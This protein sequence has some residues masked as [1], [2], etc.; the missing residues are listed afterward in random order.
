MKSLYVDGKSGQK[1]DG[2]SGQE[3]YGRTPDSVLLDHELSM[4][5]RVV[6]AFLGGC[7]HQGC[8]VRVGHRRI[9]SKIG[10][11][12]ETVGLAIHELAERGH[13]TI[14]GSGKARRIY[15][16]NSKIFGSKQRDGIQDVAIGPSGTPRLV[17]APRQR[18]A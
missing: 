2:K 6:F 8:T 12:R 16:L 7:A 18:T 11:N 15:H 4:T 13:L 14:I 10:A 9:A 5:A 17:S 1:V 3:H